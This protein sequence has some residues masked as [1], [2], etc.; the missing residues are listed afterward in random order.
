M[1]LYRMEGVEIPVTDSPLRYPGGKT[2]LKDFIFKLIHVN[3]INKFTYVE[4]FAGGGGIAI[5]LLLSGK[6]KEIIINDLDR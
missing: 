5:S 1:I 3:N 2:Q 4:P 6:A